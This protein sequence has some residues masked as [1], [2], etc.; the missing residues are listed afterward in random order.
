MTET[1]GTQEDPRD[2][3]IERQKQK[4]QHF[5]QYKQETEAD[6]LNLNLEISQLKRSVYQARAEA[7]QHADALEQ[8]KQA[9]I[10]AQ[11][12]ELNTDNAE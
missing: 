12:A 2:A 3:L 5:E 8:R 4:L 7:L 1:I 9:D 11:I 6:V 10:H